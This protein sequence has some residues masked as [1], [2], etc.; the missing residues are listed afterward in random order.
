MDYWLALWWVFPVA[1]PIC[2]TVC[3][4]GIEGAILFVPFF[5]IVFPI[6]AFHLDPVQAVSIG[7]MTEI[8]G[9]ASSLIAF[10]RARLI[11]FDIAVKS[12]LKSVPFA[13]AGGFLSFVVPQSV[14]LFVIALVLLLTAYGLYRAPGEAK[15]LRRAEAEDPALL[16]VAGGSGR[17]DPDSR[18]LVDRLGRVYRYRY[19]NDRRRAAVV[20][21]GGLFEGLVGFGIGVLGVSDLVLR[22]IPIRVAIGSSHFIIMVTAL[23]AVSP[24]IIEVARGFAVVPWNVLAMTVP[25]VLIGGQFAAFV[26]GIV[27]PD[28]IRRFLIL[29]LVLLSCVTALR[30]LRFLGAV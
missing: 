1:L 6:L 2:I 11:D 16:P 18:V 22:G 12:A 20:S 29:L 24:H 30:G 19:R 27:P 14:L 28:R 13:L 4:V 8:F 26:A 23:A 25:A 5:A 21:L 3:T 9:F 7:L 17:G 15:L 10:W